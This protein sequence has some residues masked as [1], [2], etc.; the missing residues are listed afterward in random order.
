MPRIYVALASN[1]AN[2]LPQDRQRLRA[3]AEV[4]ENPHSQG[5][6]DQEKLEACR[7]ADAVIVGRSGG[8]LTPE[9]VRSAERLQA[10]A[11][12]GGSVRRIQPQALLDR[13]ITIINTGQAM[14]NA[15]AEFSL[16]MMLC[17]LRDIPH[18]I[19]TL[20]RD[21]WG[22]ARKPRDLS[23]KAVGLVGFGMIARRVAD[24]LQPFQATVRA[25]DPHV[26]PEDIRSCR[27]EPCTLH[28]LLRQSV[29]VSLHAGLTKETRG[30]L[31]AH[32]LA[33]MPEGALLVN[34]ARADLVDEEALLAEL[35]RERIS[36]A[37]NVFWKEP[38]PADH[39]IRG[40]PNVILTPHQGGLTQDTQR[41]HSRSIVDD[42]QR[43]F[44]GEQPA[45]L[46]TR[47]MLKQMT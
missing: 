35:R 43:F 13:G 27:A 4:I 40:L 34:T 42:L 10:V 21:G 3:F 32:E 37:L 12:V 16:A 25:Y 20:R 47:D 1:D 6:T 2:L 36:A 28:D 8:G 26:L 33:L 29:I 31:G 46:V 11:L 24:L 15:V 22:R 30:I 18:M 23:G 17:G 9:T 44:R 14:A 5:A 19:E 7:D 41:R 39:S 38:L 45:G